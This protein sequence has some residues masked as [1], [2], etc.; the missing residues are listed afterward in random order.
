MSNTQLREKLVE[1]IQ[2][3]HAMEQNVVLMLDSLI[4]MTNHEATLTRLLEHR[5]ETQRHER[6]LKERL[7]ELGDPR[8]WTADG[9]AV[10]GSL[11]KAVTDR[12][13]TDRPLRNAR[14][15]YITEHTE[16]AAYEILERMA[17]RLGDAGTAHI[18]RTIRQDEE[19]MAGWIKA[20]W[21]SFVDLNLQE[22]GIFQV[23]E[24]V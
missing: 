11:L 9:A 4:C 12:M 5:K 22:A 13:R 16:I 2:D 7:Q 18:A 23:P 6:L 15:A 24:L 17:V 21:D 20:H 14:D 19:K 10:A 3:A 1:H 8:S